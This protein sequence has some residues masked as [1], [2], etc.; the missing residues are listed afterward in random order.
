MK[1][2]RQAIR[3][4]KAQQKKVFT[5]V[6]WTSIAL[7]AIVVG[8]F[9]VSSVTAPP[10]PTATLQATDIPAADMLGEVVP[11]S[12]ANDHITEGSDPGVYSSNPPTS[13]HHYP[14]WANTKFYDTNTYGQYPQGYLVHNLEHGYVIFWYNCK[15]LS[16]SQCADL[17]T[18]IK[19]VMEAVG[20]F[21]VIAYPWDSIDVPVVLTSW[22]YKLS[23]KTFDAEM[24]RKFV[25]QHRNHAPEPA[26]P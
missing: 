13:G 19:A 10:K 15:I 25:D 17:K 22:G 3:E 24:A 23:F 7:L 20:N 16:D 14:V 4:A 1:S 12:G 21:K 8:Y 6:A 5:I 9:I 11:A 2:K 26:A 18:Q